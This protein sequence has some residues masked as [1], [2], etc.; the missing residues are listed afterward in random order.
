MK[1]T[2]VMA[3][4][5]DGK[6]GKASDHLANWTSSEDKKQFIDITKRA[7]VII[8]GKN[9]FNT[10]KQPLKDRL[11]VVFTDDKD[12]P[13]IDNVMWAS[14]EIKPVLEELEN[15]GYKEVVLGGGSYL[16]TLFLKQGLVDEMIIT[17]EPKV[18]GMG[19]SLFKEE[20]DIDLELLDIKKLN[21]NT[22][23]LH[24]KVI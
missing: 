23:N 12:L 3:I 24:Y 17:I 11:N 21:N 15:K 8:M 14:G 10:F 20:F 9:T 7:G 16:N 19:L 6:I 5:L 22:I 18:F 4:T 13:I 2:L 1:V